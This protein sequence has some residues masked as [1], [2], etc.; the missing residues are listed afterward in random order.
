MN[1][2]ASRCA[3][4]RF[5]SFAPADL[6]DAGEDIGDRL[7]LSVMMNTRPR[8]RCHLEYAAQQMVFFFLVPRSITYCSNRA[9]PFAVGRRYPEP[10]GAERIGD[11][12]DALI[13]VNW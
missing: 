4:G 8:S 10:L 1:E 3:R 12:P 11:A 5:S 9:I 13:F 7:L 2:I 6:A